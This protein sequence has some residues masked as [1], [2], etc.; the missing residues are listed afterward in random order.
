[1][2]RIFPKIWPAASSFVDV[3]TRTPIKK[4][5]RIRAAEKG[6]FRWYIN[7]FNIGQGVCEFNKNDG[8]WLE[9]SGPIVM[10]P[11]MGWNGKGRKF[12]PQIAA[13]SWNHQ[14]MCRIQFVGMDV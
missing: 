4:K 5:K 12:H 10:R 11:V 6:G 1:M 8:T 9:K 2:D 7:I 13:V 3:S 14:N